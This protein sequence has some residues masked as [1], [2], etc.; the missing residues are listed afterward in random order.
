MVSVEGYRIVELIGA[1]IFTFV[2]IA[3]IVLIQLLRDILA[4]KQPGLFLGISIVSVFFLIYLYNTDVR[5]GT[6]MFIN[7]GLFCLLVI[8]GILLYKEWNGS[9]N[10]I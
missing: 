9:Q 3:G 2:I 4:S 7:G 8:A 10:Q 6:I 5:I 1:T